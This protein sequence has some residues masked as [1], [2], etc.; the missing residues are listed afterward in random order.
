[1]CSRPVSWS[2]TSLAGGLVLVAGV[3]VVVLGDLQPQKPVG[4]ADQ[5]DDV[6]VGRPANPVPV[7]RNQV[8]TGAQT[9]ELGRAARYDTAENTG[10]LA[11]YRETEALVASSQL[12]CTRPVLHAL[13]LAPTVLLLLLVH[14]VHFARLLP[15]IV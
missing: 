14:P 4:S 12:D 1:M 11:G 15:G 7:H 8:V 3:A 5:G 10:L 2:G 9:R 6:V 13:L